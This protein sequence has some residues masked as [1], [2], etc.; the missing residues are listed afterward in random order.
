[1][2]QG[3]NRS[4]AELWRLKVHFR[5]PP[6]VRGSGR[7]RGHGTELQ[8]CPKCGKDLK[9]G[10]HHVGCTAGK[11]APRQ[12]AKRRRQT[13]ETTEDD[14]L[15]DTFFETT[16]TDPSSHGS[17]AWE[18]SC[19]RRGATY[20]RSNT[21]KT[22][23]PSNH[24]E[25]K[26]GSGAS[27]IGDDA[28]LVFTRPNGMVDFALLLKPPEPF[29]QPS[30]PEAMLRPASSGGV[31]PLHTP[32][33]PSG[34]DWGPNPFQIQTV[35][36]IQEEL[37][38]RIPSPPPLPDDWNDFH[39]P[40]GLLFDFDQFD[41]VLSM[42]SHGKAP[43]AP[44][45]GAPLVTIS[46]TMDPSEMSN[47][48]DNYVWQI[49]F[50]G[51][52]DLVPKRVTAHLHQRDLPS[53]EAAPHHSGSMHKIHERLN[54][55]D[56]SDHYLADLPPPPVEAFQVAAEEQQPTTVTVT[57]NIA[58]GPCGKPNYTVQKIVKQGG[59]ANGSL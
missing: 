47:P 33:L 40:N 41:P 25:E 7:E 32:P 27:G 50:A 14:D 57:Y 48:S 22:T 51:E 13:N 36:G 12:A 46:T 1:M 31:D 20:S 21:T 35:A 3:C 34:F 55:L 23:R 10:K 19:R 54:S 26:V 44:S 38:P 18:E 30:L 37:S 56:D 15:P 6:D 4:F 24:D 8:Y 52:N 43:P 11:T 49:M 39:Q 29:M 16:T 9:P 53:V 5:A 42:R 17:G 28:E 58:P 59:D 45:G 2:L